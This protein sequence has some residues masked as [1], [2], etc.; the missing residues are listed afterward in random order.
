MKNYKNILILKHG[1]LGDF[2][3]LTGRFAS[4]RHTWPKAHITLVTTKPYLELT[5]RM[6]YFDDYIIDNRT[7][8]P[9]D[10]IKMMCLLGSGK[11]D[12][13]IDLQRQRRTIKR[14]YRLGRLW[15]KN[16][17]RWAFVMPDGLTFQYTPPKH[18]LCWGKCQESFLKCPQ[19]KN[20]VDFCKANPKVLAQL[21][22]KFVLLIPGC[23]ANSPHKRWPATSYAELAKRLGKKGITTVV[24]G[25]KIEAEIAKTICS[26][27]STAI[28]FCGKS[29]F[30]DIPGIVKKSMASIGND[31]GPQHMAEVTGVPCVSLFPTAHGKAAIQSPTVR[32]FI[33]DN[34]ADIPVEDVEKALQ[35]LWHKA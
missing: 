4:I 7:K 24:L 15:S 16:G 33:S 17:F 13:I 12:L 35:S 19:E 22:K 30:F 1:S 25:T 28:D 23:S 34:I 27:T 3:G 29:S 5:K 2:I 21:P 8:N 18:R 20:N 11:Y 26:Y 9:I 32:N 10:Y 14:Y 6:G 31:T